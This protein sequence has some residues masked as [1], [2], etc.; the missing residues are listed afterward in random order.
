MTKNSRMTDDLLMFV[1][2]LADHHR[3]LTSLRGAIAFS[4]DPRFLKYRRIMRQY[5]DER[6]QRRRL[7]GSWYSLIRRGYLQRRVFGESEGYIL[8]QKGKMKSYRLRT[9]NP[10]GGKLPNGQWLMVFFDVPESKRKVRD[11]LRRELCSLGFRSV[12]KSVWVTRRQV[13]GQLQELIALL[14]VGRFVKPLLVRALPR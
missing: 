9:H 12:Q 5:L 8:S 6:A 7:Y 4:D 11:L 10:R 2:A 14:N 1:S 13:S 3:R